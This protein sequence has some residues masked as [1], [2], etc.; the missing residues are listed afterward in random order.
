MRWRDV[1]DR[2]GR[3]GD[4]AADQIPTETN[5]QRTAAAKPA[6]VA[7]T[8]AARGS[9]KPP[10]GFKIIEVVGARRRN[11]CRRMSSTDGRRAPPIASR[12]CRRS[13]PRS[14]EG[15]S[16]TLGETHAAAA[17]LPL[18]DRVQIGCYA[19]KQRVG[20]CTSNYF[21]ASR[22]RRDAAGIR[23]EQAF[24]DVIFDFDEEFPPPGFVGWSVQN[25][26]WAEDLDESYD[27]PGY[28]PHGDGV[29]SKTGSRAARRAGAAS[30][31]RRR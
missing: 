22:F 3:L 18:A 2:A 21:V 1:Q 12:R 7:S 4:V 13:T 30:A 25:L 29:R 17:T 16:S 20:P 10:P 8:N 27:R 19:P 9:G 6:A 11:S 28:P 24:E 14:G 15:A 5:A 23:G 26:T 31:P